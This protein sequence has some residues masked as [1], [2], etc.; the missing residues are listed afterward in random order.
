M[1]SRFFCEFCGKEVP[2]NAE[3]CPSCGAQF[4]GVRCPLCHFEGHPALFNRGCPQCYY[5][6]AGGAV[7]DK[8]L[9]AVSEA[10]TSSSR[11]ASKKSSRGWRSLFGG[12]AS[13]KREGRGAPLILY[14]G[15][16]FFLLACLILLMGIYSRL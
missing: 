2:F 5:T 15:V 9:Q 12:K 1:E 10:G 6:P 4:K 16:F 7:P 14:Y 3:V 8:P 11:G 13:G